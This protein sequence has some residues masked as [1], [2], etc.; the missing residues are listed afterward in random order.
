[1]PEMIYN[2]M[3][4]AYNQMEKNPVLLK[5]IGYA[6]SIGNILNGGGPKG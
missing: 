4:D 6:L 3:H 1:M 2:R 5:M